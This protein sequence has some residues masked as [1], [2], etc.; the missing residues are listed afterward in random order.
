MLEKLFG[1]IPGNP[2]ARLSPPNEKG[3]PR[4]GQL[5]F[6]GERWLDQRTLSCLELVGPAHFHKVDRV[7]CPQKKGFNGFEVVFP[8]YV[9]LVG[10]EKHLFSLV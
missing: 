10:N 1:I 9:I 4:R 3:N 7:S 6:L 2:S 5:I 8:S